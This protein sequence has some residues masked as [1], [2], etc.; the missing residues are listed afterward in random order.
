MSE[1]PVARAY[2]AA[3]GT[4]DTQVAADGWVRE[5]LWQRYARVFQAGQHVLDVGCGTGIDALFLAAR[6]LHVT[7]VDISPQMIARL[8]A[9]ATA[10]NLDTNITAHVFDLSRLSRGAALPFA[11]A[12]GSSASFD[13]I[14]SAF[15]GL[16]ALPDLQPFA[17]AAAR[18]LKPQGR[19][20]LHMLNRFSLWEWLRLVARG[21]WRAAWRLGRRPERTFVIGEQPVPHVLYYPRDAYRTFFAPSFDL[22]EANSIGAFRPPSDADWVPAGLLPFLERLERRLSAARP[23]LNWGR[24]FVLDLLRR[25]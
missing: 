20:I 14:I 3:A 24:F 8:R 13:G 5:L 4:Y 1:S 7:A 15:A 19:M 23:F 9:K 10:Q 11:A 22:V 17:A 12:P 21:R 6:G 2:D 25:P 18:L 16:N